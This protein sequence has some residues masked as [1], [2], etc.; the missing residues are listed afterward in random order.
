M[1][2]PMFCCCIDRS[3]RE[4]KHAKME[5]AFLYSINGS[6]YMITHD[7]GLLCDADVCDI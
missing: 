5:D 3:Q 7:V 6:G 1:Y 4:R 2:Q